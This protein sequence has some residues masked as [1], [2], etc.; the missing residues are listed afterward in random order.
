MARTIP[1]GNTSFSSASPSVTVRIHT[2]WNVICVTL[3]YAF[4]VIRNFSGPIGDYSES[5][6]YEYLPW[7]ASKHL[8]LWPIPHL[9]LHTNEVLYPFG[10]NVALQSWCVER[11]ILFALLKPHFPH[12]PLLQM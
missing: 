6:L 1:P 10:G 11:D 7:Y 9:S 5:F 12:A 8:S 4:A 2:T 3:F